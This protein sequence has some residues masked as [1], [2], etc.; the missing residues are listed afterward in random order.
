MV[1]NIHAKSFEK[2]HNKFINSHDI[3]FIIKI[4]F[5]I[6]NKYLYKIKQEIIKIIRKIIKNLFSSSYDR[7]AR[8]SSFLLTIVAHVKDNE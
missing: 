1:E 4:T 5:V 2:N 6:L 8:R 7:E 3:N